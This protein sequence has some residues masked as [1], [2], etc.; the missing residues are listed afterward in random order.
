MAQRPDA[1]GGR[2]TMADLSYR[3][4][5]RWHWRLAYDP[6]AAHPDRRRRTARDR[7]VADPDR[8]AGRRFARRHR[9]R[10]LCRRRIRCRGGRLPAE[11]RLTGTPC[12]RAVA[13][14][15]MARNR[16]VTGPKK[17]EDQHILGPEPP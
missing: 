17:Q 5:C 3:S 9:V 6:Y 7:T 12:P 2:P 8:A 16:A 10:P 13:R 15:R 1:N 4:G 11:T 14:A